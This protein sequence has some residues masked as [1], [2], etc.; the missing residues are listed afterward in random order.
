MVVGSGLEEEDCFEGTFT[1]AEQET[2]LVV[3]LEEDET[4]TSVR[5]EQKRGPDDE[6]QGGVSGSRRESGGDDSA[7]HS[8]VFRG[9]KRGGLGFGGVESSTDE[10]LPQTRVWG[11]P[12]MDEGGSGTRIAPSSLGRRVG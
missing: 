8:A 1:E 7:G 5:V 9:T 12:F 10:N 3:E 2:E 11:L 4:G 6:I